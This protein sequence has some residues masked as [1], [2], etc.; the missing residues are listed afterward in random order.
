M[1][2]VSGLV[3]G[4]AAVELAQ[5]EGLGSI[6]NVTASPTV[7]GVNHTLTMKLREPEPPAGREGSED[8]PL[9]INKKLFG[10]AEI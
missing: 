10:S 7:R 3:S 2:K 8:T 9:A 6:V 4:Q 1:L 5:L